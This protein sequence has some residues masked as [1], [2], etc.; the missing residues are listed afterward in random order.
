MNMQIRNG[1]YS[2]VVVLM[3][4][5]CWEATDAWSSPRRRKHKTMAGRES[6]AFIHRKYTIMFTCCARIKDELFKMVQNPPQKKP[7]QN[8]QREKKNRWKSTGTLSELLGCGG[9]RPTWLDA[10]LPGCSFLHAVLH[11]VVELPTLQGRGHTHDSTHT[12]NTHTTHTQHNT[13]QD[14]PL[15]KCSIIRI[16]KESRYTLKGH[17][18]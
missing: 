7:F 11:A 15:S 8:P 16:L 6:D 2:F 14:A 18:I 13:A 1:N 17:L 10:L 4:L 9:A 5:R 12:H 3:V